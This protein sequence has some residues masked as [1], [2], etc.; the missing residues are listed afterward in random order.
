MFA[1]HSTHVTIRG[2]LRIVGNSL[3]SSGL[4]AQGITLRQVAGLGAKCL[5]LLSHPAGWKS[6]FHSTFLSLLRPAQV[7][8]DPRNCGMN[9]PKPGTTINSS[10]LDTVLIKGFSHSYTEVT[11]WGRWYPGNDAGT[12]IW[13]STAEHSTRD[14]VCGSISE[15]RRYRMEKVQG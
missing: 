14:H 5:P 4:R 3:P 9:R 10:S 7:C 2:Q 13:T 6:N 15:V 8:I 11:D 1:C 12:L